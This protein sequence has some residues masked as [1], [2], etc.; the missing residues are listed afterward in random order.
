MREGDWGE[1]EEG[2]EG[3][4]EQGGGEGGDE[5]DIHSEKEFQPLLFCRVFLCAAQFSLCVSV[6]SV[7]I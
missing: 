4:R 1:G 6:L 2:G 5:T 7:S 3:E